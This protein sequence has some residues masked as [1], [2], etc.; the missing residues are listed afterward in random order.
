MACKIV[1]IGG[2]S[3]IWTP[4][5]AGDLFLKDSL[6][7]S[8]LSL[9]DI[10]P[11]ALNTMTLYCKLLNKA[12]NRNWNII[13]QSQTEAL[14]GAD[15]VCI[16]IATGGLAAMH[17]D[18]TIPEAFGIYHTV[19]DT[20]GPGGISRALRDIPVF[21]DIAQEMEKYCPSTPLIHVTNPLSQLTRA[22]NK[23]TNIKAIGLC[24]NY[25][26]TISMLAEYFNVPREEIHATSIGVNHFSWF[27]DLTVKGRDVSSEL[28]LE[29]YVEYYKAKKGPLITNTTDD[30]I[31]KMLKGENM[32]YYFNFVLKDI[33]GYLPVGS[34]NHVAEA[35][36]Y[37][38]NSEET[39]KK[40]YI[41]RKGVLPRRQM[42]KDQKIEKVN[43]I[44]SGKA[45]IPVPNASFEYFAD[46]VAALHLGHPTRAV[47][48]MPN[49]GQISNLPKDVSVETW[50][51]INGSGI[52]PLQ[53]GE[54]PSSIYALVAPI[55]AEQEL[56]V[57]AAYTGS[58]DLVT[59]AVLATPVLQNKESAKEIAQQLIKANKELIP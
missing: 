57:E 49:Q 13:A 31:Q 17:N 41:R 21:L 2:G 10:D 15:Y 33:Y 22:V 59:K 47:V 26:G 45:D 40:Y 29:R 35:L 27:K 16:S 51:E 18:Y 19:G 43:A 6:D 44:V 24:H 4:T 23:Y 56:T 32:E 1:F 42:L 9:V 52:F 7:G 48:T 38:L 55:V 53:S 34:S 14:Q 20:S 28:S 36:P 12:M 58:I 3:Y 46:I 8:T 37:Y 54:L 39:L 11:I 25:S 30:E 5:F 50:A